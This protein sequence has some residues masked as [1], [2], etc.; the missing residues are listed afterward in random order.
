MARSSP[1]RNAA[2]PQSAAATDAQ[3]SL[4][5]S[6]HLVPVLFGILAF[7]MCLFPMR[8]TDFYW[9]LRTGELIWQRLAIPALDLYTYTDFDRRWIDLH[10]GF[11]L[12]VTA[13]YHLSGVNGIILFKA[14]CY[15]AAVMIGWYATGRSISPWLKAI[16]WFPALIAITGRAYERPEM[17]SLV[18]LAS[19]LWLL[20]RIPQS[21]RYI[22]FVPVLLILW[23]NFHALFIL[24]VVV[25]GAFV[26]GGLIRS[27]LKSH[28]SFLLDPLLPTR[29]LILL[30]GLAL[31]APLVNPY[32]EQGW[33]F[34][35]ELYRKFS[36]EHDYYSP[37]VGEFQ[38][39]IVFLKD[40]LEKR[41]QQ[42]K[43]LSF[44]MFFSG[45]GLIYPLAEL[46]VFIIAV[47]VLLFIL[48]T[49]RKRYIYRILCFI[50]F[51]FLY[52]AFTRTITP[53]VLLPVALVVLGT[54]RKISIYRT[55]LLVGFSHLAWV[56]TRNTSVFSLV[57]A[58][59]ACGLLDDRA[60]LRGTPP[61]R[62]TQYLDQIA[63]ILI[64]CMMGCV[65]SGFWGTIAEPGKAFRLGEAPAWFGHE[66]VKFAGQEGMPQRAFLAHFGLAGAYIM[67]N[68]PEKK[69]F[70]DPRL[71]V[72]SRR[73]FEKW[74]QTLEL[75]AQGNPAW[76]G[77]VNPDGKGLPAVILDS[78]SSR[79]VI[80]GMFRIPAWRL[81]F[82]DQAAAVFIPASLADQLRLPMADPRPLHQP[83]N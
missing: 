42:G 76:E 6:P 45:E 1:P 24:G 61:P 38:Q 62:E 19:M 47:W 13:L 74:D 79:E 65:A 32:L 25:C 17:I 59:V 41:A 68:G 83:P 33:V 66:A 22:W 29:Q 40:S 71:E 52:I 31:A 56:A 11:Q 16:I 72:C 53:F 70:M 43:P 48:V 27:L 55:L 30:G 5:W 63:A 46:S 10:W 12:L 58:V 75:M 67:H 36:S 69:V 8:D 21:P 44:G 15:T 14:L 50:G 34:P 35:L 28:T 18:S 78:R 4:G 51:S 77:I 54:D 9:H 81:V 37:R 73:T 60:Q 57:G 23:T 39:P 20:E 64:V 80:N 3:E 82:A 7:L 2:Q 26:V 49:D